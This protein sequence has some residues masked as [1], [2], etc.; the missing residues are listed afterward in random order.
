MQREVSI[1]VGVNREIEIGLD[2]N[3]QYILLHWKGNVLT[4]RIETGIR[5]RAQLEAFKSYLDRLSIHLRE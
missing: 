5:T 1:F 4:D 2:D 3:N